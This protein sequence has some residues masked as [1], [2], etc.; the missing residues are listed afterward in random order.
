M[1]CNKLY[2]MLERHGQQKLLRFWNE[3]DYAG[4]EKLSSQI[5]ALDFANLDDLIDKYV[6]HKPTPPMPAKF[7]P[8]PFFPLVPPDENTAAY[9]E[10]AVE[11]GESLL[12]AGKVAVLTV[13]GGQGTRL[14]F[15]GPKGTYPIGPVSEKTLFNFFADAIARNQQKYG[16]RISW[17]IMTSILNNDATV[18]FFKSRNYFGLAPEQVIFFVQGTMPAIGY[19]GKLLL[20]EKSSLAL[21]PDGHGGTLW[22]LRVSGAL[23]RMAADGVEYISYFQVDNPLVPV[24]DPKFIGLHSLEKA[25]IS[26][27]SLS[28]TGPFEKLGN[29]C[30]ADGHVWIIEYSDLADE[31]AESR[32]PDGSLRFVAGSPAIHVINRDFIERL[33]RDGKPSLPWHRAD[34][35]VP[36]IDDSGNLVSPDKPNAVKLESFIFD[37][38]PMADRVMLLEADRAEEFAPTKNAT[39]V[40]SAESCR[41]MIVAQAKRRL[42]AAGVDV[43]KAGIVEISPR[44]AVND[45]DVAE[46]CAAHNI[47]EIVG[48]KIYLE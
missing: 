9:Y 33:T 36:F 37:A 32:N 10:K 22:A 17:Y 48:E 46:Y 41:A 42:K 5:Q 47:T 25:Q 18:K 45:A 29:F 24:V 38:L 21:S 44:V 19:D 1:D 40:D 14:G 20:A 4:R 31:L 12:R 34:K 15:D 2:S 16:A 7:D 23:D 39:G 27:I 3:L 11:V 26:A 43:S 8:A 30:T 6:M 28:K 35:K 13:A